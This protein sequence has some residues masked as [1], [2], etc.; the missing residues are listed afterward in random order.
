MAE[1]WPD[2]PFRD[3]CIADLA[4]Y[5]DVARAAGLIPSDCRGRWFGMEA[6]EART[7]QLYDALRDRRIVYANEAWN[8]NSP[9]G[10]LVYQR[11][12][13]PTE[14]I[15]GTATCLDLALLFAGFAIAADIRPLIG[16]R[17]KPKPHALVVLDVT[18][19]LSDLGKDRLRATPPGFIADPDVPEI[20][21]L[22]PDRIPSDWARRRPGWVVVDVSKAARRSSLGVLASI[23]EE[24]DIAVQDGVEELRDGQQFT[25]HKWIMADVH[26][27]RADRTPYR[28][29]TG[30][31]VPAIHGYLPALP[32][33][34][35]YPTRRPLLQDLHQAASGQRPVTVV[36]HGDS[37]LGKS[38]L[39]HRVAV[40]A[41]HGC[42]WFL[43]ASDTKALTRSL[44]EA[45][46]QE[47]SLRDEQ[48]NP[49]AAAEKPDYGEDRALAAAALAR[50]READRPWVVVLDNCDSTPD[51]AGLQ[52]L[53][54]QPIQPG[55]IV[56]ITTTDPDWAVLAR[57][58]GWIAKQL[59]GLDSKD[60]RLL[61]LPGWAESA[62]DGK[63]LIAQALAALRPDAGKQRESSHGARLVWDLLQEE[64]TVPPEA[65]TVARLLAWCPPEPV[66]V[67]DLL[68]ITGSPP[69]A[70]VDKPL[71]DLRF[72]TSTLPDAQIRVSVP[73]ART[74]VPEAGPAIQM[75]RLFAAAV[76]EQTWEEDQNLAATTIQRLLSHGR[77]R[78]LFT[79][80]ADSAA[81]ELLEDMSGEVT[82]AVQVL[83]D[84]QAAGLLW[85]GLGH[86]RERRGPVD[87][88]DE[89][90]QRALKLLNHDSSPFEAA[91]CL[92]GRARLVF[93]RKPSNTALLVKAR[94]DT[95][96][97]QE[98]LAGMSE[99]DARQMREQA[100][101]LSWLI[102]QVI[103]EREKDAR[104]REKLLLRT[105]EELWQS[106]EKRLALAREGEPDQLAADRSTEPVPTDGLGAE[107]AYYNLAGVNIQ[108]AK[109]HREL[110]GLAG[111]ISACQD[112]LLGQVRADLTEAARVYEVTR[113]LRERRYGGRPHP[114]LASCLHGQALVA[115]YRAD[116]LHETGQLENVFDFEGMAMEQRL[117]VAGSL[118]GPGNPAAFRDTD[119][120]KS[121]D[122]MMKLSVSGIAV[123]YDDPAEAVE[124]VKRIFREAVGE[125]FGATQ[126]ATE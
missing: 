123:R 72:V 34:T 8:P 21:H 77:G 121:A 75:H 95:E 59:A 82:K 15:Q 37:G 73:D 86:I 14:T 61:Q 60:L 94:Q 109:T 92:I 24:F 108:L 64:P 67:A 30:R 68:E 118:N 54:P 58:R 28:P 88:S 12:R 4:R 116:L 103:A 49:A 104:K 63:P 115:Y 79:D 102:E 9:V 80:A 36:L 52:E 1:E 20:C 17:M 5:V 32:A 69:A 106:Y 98:L 117:K 105:R 114:H 78:R 11:L 42:G 81:L 125:W 33:F 119:V 27:L 84:E 99:P 71:A 7:R 110:A 90:F 16:I 101:A 40:A 113:A 22:A 96:D 26:R 29:P 39:A 70:G 56:I 74:A 111:D 6:G 93:Q 43:N 45:E 122:F 126:V 66:D 35:S 31:A 62:A 18:K 55:Q 83:A 107:R 48:A 25:G 46:R 41:D 124:N 57:E 53:M 97:G 89:H 3:D 120:R 85:H 50:L 44:A 23:G 51:T 91:E 100:N 112:E 13:G 38:M 2:W 76:R 19:P 87:I 10:K 65:I 47:Q